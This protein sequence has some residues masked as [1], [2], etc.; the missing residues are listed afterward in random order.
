M[1]HFHVYVAARR[2][3]APRVARP[4]CWLLWERK[5]NLN[6]HDPQD[7]EPQSAWWT[8]QAARKAITG[9]D[10]REFMVRRCEHD[11]CA[12]EAPES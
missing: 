12:P 2:K 5:K 9:K 1:S 11:E 10:G 7:T 6:P 4:T 3:G 8:N